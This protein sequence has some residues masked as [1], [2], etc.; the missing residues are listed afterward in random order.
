MRLRGGIDSHLGTT[1]EA[2]ALGIIDHHLSV[3]LGG[4]GGVAGLDGWWAG[5]LVQVWQTMTHTMP[6]DTMLC[7]DVGTMDISWRVGN[8]LGIITRYGHQKS[9]HQP[10]MKNDRN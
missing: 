6:R 9:N 7:C 2:D 8:Q 4:L 5:G 1:L 10:V 3:G